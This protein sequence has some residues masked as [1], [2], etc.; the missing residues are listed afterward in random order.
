MLVHPP[1]RSCCTSEPEP[2]LLESA[3]APSVPRNQ[4]LPNHNFKFMSARNLHMN[5]GPST[6][7]HP[8]NALSVPNL[9]LL[10][11]IKPCLPTLNS[12]PRVLVPDTPPLI[13]HSPLLAFSTQPKITDPI[14]L[15]PNSSPLAPLRGPALPEANYQRV[16]PISY[17]T[18]RKVSAVPTSS[19]SSSSPSPT[20][21]RPRP[22]NAMQNVLNSA[23]RGT[24]IPPSPVPFDKHHLTCLGTT[25]LKDASDSSSED[26]R[27]D[28]DDHPAFYGLERAELQNYQDEFEDPNDIRAAWQVMEEELGIV[29]DEESSDTD[30]DSE[31]EPRVKRS[32][33]ASGYAYYKKAATP[34]ALNIE[35]PHSVEQPAKST[36]KT[37]KPKENTNSRLKDRIGRVPQKMKKDKGKQRQVVDEPEDVVQMSEEETPQVT[38]EES[39]LIKETLALFKPGS[40][41]STGLECA[42]GSHVLAA[43]LTLSQEKRAMFLSISH[44][45]MARTFDKMAIQQ[46][47]KRRNINYTNSPE[48]K[49]TRRF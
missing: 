43:L 37:Q 20:L 23:H 5:A 40:F 12:A 19:S 9:Q 44:D 17:N 33:D 38:S 15:V 45:E 46:S 26:D 11:T 25:G 16:K 4:P 1:Y 47:I 34:S 36:R 18:S 48:H 42:E 31:K 22:V 21:R 13:P 3:L 41:T 39:M 28:I 29:G 35:K 2:V 14:V 30:S 7:P 27:M 32:I 8:G 49:R 6:S 10:P 24:P